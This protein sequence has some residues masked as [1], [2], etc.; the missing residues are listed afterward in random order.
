MKK[1]IIFI[2]FALTNFTACSNYS[3]TNNSEE[4][5]MQINNYSNEALRVGIYIYDYP[6]HNLSNDNGGGF[7]H[8]L[9]N[10]IANASGFKIQFIPMQFSELIPAL[11]R[12]HI[13]LIIAAM[14][15]TD[16]RKELVS[17]SDIYLTAGQSFVVNKGNT[18]IKTTNDLI[19]KSVGVIK[20][21]VSDMTISKA[22][23][24][25]DIK[26]FDIAGS[27]LLSLKKGRIDAI[28]M[29]KLTCINYI[30]YDRDLQIVETIELP[31]MGYAIAVR[32]D[33]D[34]L[35]NKVNSGLQEII[36]NGTYDKLA[37][38]Y[39]GSNINNNTNQ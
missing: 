7:D 19:G 36:T 24:I 18:N 2:L 28:M 3:N 13:D 31:N 32:K 11:R 33:D 25:Y 5:E 14:T 10:E 8:D 35:L 30:E 1:I 16:E 20:D 22:E 6:M 34:I 4:N 21:T 15:V 39:L 26:R 37:V 12:K 27:A 23:G 29:D 9:M 38:K 17:F